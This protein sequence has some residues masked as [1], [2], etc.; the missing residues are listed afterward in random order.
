VLNVLRIVGRAARRLGRR[1]AS[2]VFNVRVLRVGG[3][4]AAV[5]VLAVIALYLRDNYLAN[6]RDR[7]VSLTWDFLDRPTQFG[8]PHSDFRPGQPVRDALWIGIKNTALA[9]VVGVVATTIIGVLVGVL[10]LSSSWLARKVATLYVEVLRNIPVLLIILFT[11]AWLQTLPRNTDAL[12]LDGILVVSN[13][14]INV[15]SPVAGDH[16]GTYVVALAVSVAAAA[17]VWRWRTALADRTGQPH[18]RVL[19]AGGLVLGVAVVGYVALGRPLTFSHPEVVD[20]SV[21]NGISMNIPYVALTGAIALYHGSHIAEIVR[22]SIQAVPYGQTEAATALGLSSF[23][24]MRYVILPQAFRVA[25]PPTINQHLSLAK[26]TS[27]GIAVAYSDAFALTFQLVGGSRAPALQAF[28]IL[29]AIYLTF[30]L[31]ISL[32][33]NVVNRRLQLVER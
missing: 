14:W 16:L 11:V 13:R 6:L 17:A 28:V 3:Q 18:H 2:L 4:V 32:L 24:R 12:Q 31:T 15:M 5:G 19:W 27:L 33:M 22:G 26:N 30:S 1:V 25:V 21:R 29:M 9:A 7:N 10:R 23:A 8:I 20:G